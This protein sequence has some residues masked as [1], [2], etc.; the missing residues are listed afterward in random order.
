MYYL[1]TFYLDC[2]VDL[3]VDLLLMYLHLFY[4]TVNKKKKQ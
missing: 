2:L 1:V 3:M 4:M